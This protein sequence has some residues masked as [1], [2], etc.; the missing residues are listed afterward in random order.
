[1]NHREVLRHCAKPTTTCLLLTVACVL[2]IWDSKPSSGSG[3][4]DAT[5][6]MAM[7]LYFSLVE[8]A[9]RIVGYLV[10]KQ[11]I[12][13]HPCLRQITFFDFCVAAAFFLCYGVC[14]T[15]YIVYTYGPSFVERL[16]DNYAMIQLSSIYYLPKL[17]V[18]PLVPEDP[19]KFPNLAKFIRYN[20][21]DVTFVCRFETYVRDTAENVQ[22]NFEWT[23]DRAELHRQKAIKTSE[24][25]FAIQPQS[26]TDWQ[27][28]LRLYYAKETLFLPRISDED[29]GFYTCSCNLSYMVPVHNSDNRRSV[30]CIN[31]PR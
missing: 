26:R 20:T 30:V 16:G 2:T 1:M 21:E 14:P 4:D 23:Q 25:S 27:Q 12:R 28:G 15:I 22:L 10:N 31:K 7:C 3:T 24:G 11:Y 29:Y 9:I 18:I 17:V 8:G 5:Y 6:F 13:F 19:N